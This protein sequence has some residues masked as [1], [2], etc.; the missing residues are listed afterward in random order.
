[1]SLLNTTHSPAFSG[2]VFDAENPSSLNHLRDWSRP[3]NRS[4]SRW[5]RRSVLHDFDGDGVLDLLVGEFGN[6]PFLRIDCHLNIEANPGSR[7][8][9]PR[10]D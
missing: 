2:P 3:E 4:M 9:I 6:E 7:V 1:M 10:E 5:A 8:A